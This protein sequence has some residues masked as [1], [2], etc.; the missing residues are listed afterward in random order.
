MIR[1]FHGRMS[2]IGLA[3]AL[4]LGLSATARADE[5]LDWNAVLMRAVRTAGTAPPVN[6]RLMAIVHAAM[7]DALNGIDRRHTPLHVDE[8][9]PA[10]ASRRAA[11]VQAAYTALVGVYPLQAEALA[12]DLEASL[13]G[14]AADSAVEHSESI[15]RGREWGAYVAERILAWRSTDGF[16]PSPSTYQGSAAI[17]KWRPTPPAFANGFAPSLATTTPFVIPTPSS[18]RPAGPPSLTSL[19]YAQDFSEVKAIG[20]AASTVRT[21]EQ[22]TIARFWGS[23]APTFW[24][25]AAIDMARQ[26]HYSLSEHARLLALLHAAMADAGISCWDAKYFFE[27]WRPIEAIRRASMDG[28]SLT[29]EQ[30][31]WASLLT[32]PPYPEYSSGHATISGA[33]Q[34]VLTRFFGSQVPIEGWSE[35]FGES[36]VR[37]WPSFAAAADEAYESR[38][39][40]GI[41]FRFAMRDAREK[42]IAIGDYVVKN[43]AQPLPRRKP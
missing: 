3:L 28:N 5:V 19:E 13:A 1:R 7:F 18:F 33:A 15:A 4:A 31:D 29:D 25:R 34:R 41:H 21:P 30:A 12:Q 40:A 43:A 39:Y 20:S 26:R 27:F 35:A 17:G 9:A 6:I 42:G 14:I 36:Y 38:I 32:T 24:N 23:T 16:D 37:S 11:V 22:T 10:G 8:A 2:V